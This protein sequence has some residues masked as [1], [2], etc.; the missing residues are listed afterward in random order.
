MVARAAIFSLFLSAIPEGL[1]RGPS[2]QR[3]VCCCSGVVFKI[4]DATSFKEEALLLRLVEVSWKTEEDVAFFVFGNEG[5]FG[6]FLG[7][8]WVFALVVAVLLVAMLIVGVY[9]LVDF[10]FLPLVWCVVFKGIVSMGC[11]VLP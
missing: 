4:A 11:D 10:N 5:L 8:W 7:G 3:G 6:E 1:G 2:I 9:L